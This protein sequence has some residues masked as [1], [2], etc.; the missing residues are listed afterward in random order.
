M[1]L[2]SGYGCAVWSQAKMTSELQGL[3]N[4]DNKVISNR[5]DLR[6]RKH[7]AGFITGFTSAFHPA[8]QLLMI[9]LLR[10]PIR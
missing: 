9:L 7:V 2:L 8:S 3:P 1:W 6:I 4:G 10:M 5:Y